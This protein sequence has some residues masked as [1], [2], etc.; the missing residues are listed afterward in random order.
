[1]GE[2]YVYY[3]PCADL[4]FALSTVERRA[5]MCATDI[6]WDLLGVELRVADRQRDG[7]PW[8]GS[9][10]RRVAARH[11]RELRAVRE[12]AVDQVKHRVGHCDA[13]VE[14]FP[15]ATFLR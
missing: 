2:G 14:L 5:S 4:V 6:L 13:T 15:P 1:M 3:E 7:A 12:D 9:R 8:S 11:R 10:R